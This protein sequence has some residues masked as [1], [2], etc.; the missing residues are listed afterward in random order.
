MI[1]VWT[2][3]SCWTQLAKFWPLFKFMEVD[4]D[5]R[6]YCAFSR[7]VIL[8]LSSVTASRAW[9]PIE[10]SRLVNH[11]WHFLIFQTSF[12]STVQI[13]LTAWW[14]LF[15]LLRHS[16]SNGS[17]LVIFMDHIYSKMIHLADIKYSSEKDKKHKIIWIIKLSTRGCWKVLGPTRDR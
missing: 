13:F 16:V 4:F 12:P 1:K 6:F 7:S 5:V 8:G 3:R 9:L 14:T 11:R 10:V 17:H 15:E 2:V